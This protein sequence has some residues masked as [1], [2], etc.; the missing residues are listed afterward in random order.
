MKVLVL[1]ATGG[2]GREVVAQAAEQSHT[3]TVL[4][5][6]PERLD[7]AD[8]KIRVLTGDV[9]DGG[10][11]L[12]AAVAGQDVV[13]STLGV[14]NSLKSNGLIARSAP[15]I[16]NA[17][18]SQGVRRLIF[19]SAYGVGSTR[20]NAPLLPRILMGLLLGDLYRDKEAGER[21]IVRSDLDWT[22]VY[23]VS[24]TNGPRTGQY[25][26]AEC[27]DLH[28]FPRVSRADVAHFL[29]SQIRDA[30]YLRKGVIISS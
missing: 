14:G 23:P 30:H 13:I 25:R 20:Q 4:V 27:I 10:T 8:S 1:G 22:I 15:S 28:G 19:V 29:L 16:A 2:T 17:M 11:A 9:T 24:L 18:A 21:Y 6:H 26:V 12:K 5:R 3:V 7:S